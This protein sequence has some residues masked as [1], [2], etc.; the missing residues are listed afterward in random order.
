M[1]AL[2]SLVVKLALEY[3]QFTAGSDEAQKRADALAKGVQDRMDGMAATVKSAAAG[4]A[5]GLAAAFTIGAVDQ[6]LKDVTASQTAL[7]DLSHMA[8]MTVEGL[9]KLQSVSRYVGLGAQ[10]IAEASVSMTDA[11]AQAADESDGVGQALAAVGLKFDDFRRLKPEEQFRVLAGA[12][13]NF[14]DGAGKAAVMTQIMGEEGAKLLPFLRDLADAGELHAEVTLAQAEAAAEYQANLVATQAAA[15]AWKQEIASGMVPALNLATQALDEV[16]N[17]TGGLRD[18]A[19]AL[20]AD[21][22]IQRFT[23]AGITALSYLADAAQ[24]AWRGLETVGVNLGGLA[25]AIVRAV[26]GDLQGAWQILQDTGQD[27][28]GV[29]DEPTLGQRFRENMVKLKATTQETTEAV[30]KQTLAVKNYGEE[31]KAAAERQKQ[32]DKAAQDAAKAAQRELEAT[33]AARVKAYGEEVKAQEA[34]LKALQGAAG[35]AKEAVQS[36]RDEEEAHRRAAAAGITHAEAITEIA[37]AR[38]EEAYQKALAS[39]ADA[40]T[41]LALHEE[42]QARRELL[43]VMQQRGVREG[44][45]RA[46]EEITK[47]WDQVSQTVGQTLSDYIMGGG[48]DAAQYLKRLF[49][50]LV[51]QPVVNWGVQ[52]LLGMLGMGGSSAS[53]GGL[54]GIMG[55]AN[56]ASS[57]NN[58]WGALS[59]LFTGGA[60]GASSASLAYG[61]L[62]GAMGGDGLGALIAGNGSWSGV[63]VAGTTGASSSGLGSLAAAWPAAI[64]AGILASDKLFDAGFDA[65]NFSGGLNKALYGGK[66][67]ETNILGSLIGDK[68]ANMLTGAPVMSYIMSKF[69]GESRIGGQYGVAYD[70]QVVNR[71]RD[72]VYTNTGQR[73]LNLGGT[74][75]ALQNGVAYRLEGV[76]ESEADA[77]IAEAV[78]ATASGIDTLFEALGSSARLTGFW[79]GLETSGKGRGGVMA[80]GMLSNGTIFG[81]DGTGDNYAGTFFEDYSTNSPDFKTA[82]ENFELD[83]KQATLQALQAADDLPKAINLMLADI[84]VEELDTAGVDA[85]IMQIK[86]T[87]IN[88]NVLGALWSDMKMAFPTDSLID[89]TASLVALQ[90]GLDETLA[91]INTF[92]SAFYSDEEKLEMALGQMKKVLADLGLSIDPM[93]GQEAKDQYRAAANAALAAGNAEL[94]AALLNMSGAFADL[95]D[96]AGDAA[97]TAADAA[98]AAAEAAYNAALDRAWN[99]YEA[100]VRREQDLLQERMRGVQASIATLGSMSS[101]LKTNA[102]ALYG[103]VDSTSQMRGI[104]GML[105]IESALAAARQGADMMAFTGLSDAVSAARGGLNAGVYATQYEKDRDALVLAGQLSELQDITDVQLTVEERQLKALTDQLDL[106]EDMLQS[107]RDLIDGVDALIDKTLTPEAAYDILMRIFKGEGDKPGAPVGGGGSAAGGPSW[108]GGSGVASG[109]SGTDPSASKYIRDTWLYENYWAGRGTDDAALDPLADIVR[110]FSGSGDMRGLLEAA[111]SAGF[112]LSDL[113]AAATGA[114]DVYRAS[115]YKDWLG[116]AASVGV[117][118]FAAGGD[119]LGGWRLVGEEGPELEYTPP[120]RIYSN[121]DTQRMLGQLNGGQSDSAAAL[122]LT[123]KLDAT[124]VK[125]ERVATAVEQLAEQVDQIS[126]GGNAFAVEVMNRVEVKGV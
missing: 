100:A 60:A 44:N 113:Q 116:A 1:S 45:E 67:L 118:A 54:G 11:L 97:A 17:G 57:L 85:L 46:Q 83:L 14:E 38:S 76:D 78:A 68:W 47:R 50:T 126:A 41:L 117:P 71:R 2:G 62:V 6:L 42:L 53:G 23:E 15:D 123:A 13:S 28:M 35:K 24:V 37:I 102:D 109:G 110:S 25:A 18:E 92:Y 77:A 12:L 112:S 51:L 124:N 82:L 119:H 101:M 114:E 58:A 59:Q 65:N 27:M 8:G 36:A 26:Q 98:K 73:Y 52:G 125:L 106:Y 63:S 74:G 88:A 104:D 7:K 29:W 30:K 95:A 122:G 64:A 48:K 4:V 81:E 111:K 99:N 89:F 31:S 108:G 121:R 120:A 79:A 3:A 32:L 16:I 72:Q 93:L 43:E 105:Y 90:G 86:Q 80:G 39:G 20:G 34:R 87:V 115:T 84:N 9:S 33:T 66:T 69:S 70:G 56:N 49:S 22:S 5:G 10:E 21:G 103:S 94:Y 19:Q 61:N 75:D 40:E 55:L 96:R 107:T 91:G